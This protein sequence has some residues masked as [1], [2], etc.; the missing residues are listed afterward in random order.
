MREVDFAKQKTEGEN[1]KAPQTSS[2]SQNHLSFSP[3]DSS[4]VRGSLMQPASIFK[5]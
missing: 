2:V 4:L 5:K 3:T 1:K